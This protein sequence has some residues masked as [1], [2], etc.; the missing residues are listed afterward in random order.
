MEQTI[1]GKLSLVDHAPDL[2]AG[3]AR[4]ESRLGHRLL[5][6]F[7]I[8]VS[9]SR[10]MPSPFL[11]YATNTSL[12]MQFINHLA[13][14][15]I[16]YTVVKLNPQN[17]HPNKNCLHTSKFTL[18]SILTHIS[19]LVTNAFNKKVEVLNDD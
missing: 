14:D 9:P 2:Q 7:V 19:M 12:Q 10:Q 18:H 11:E 8:F 5:R 6:F 17:S 3:V 16:Q 13:I 4:F 1:Q 15:V